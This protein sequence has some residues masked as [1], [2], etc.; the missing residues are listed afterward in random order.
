MLHI[1]RSYLWEERKGSLEANVGCLSCVALHFILKWSLTETEAHHPFGLF[2]LPKASETG[3]TIPLVLKLQTYDSSSNWLH[4][5]WGSASSSLCLYSVDFTQLDHSSS[6][7]LCSS[8]PSSFMWDCCF[9]LWRFLGSPFYA[10]H[11]HFHKMRKDVF[12]LFSLEHALGS[13]SFVWGCRP[14]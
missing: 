12:L 14:E 4:G 9:L 13:W 1:L 6:R 2:E 5:W 7:F 11:I 10:Y 8:Q 3:A